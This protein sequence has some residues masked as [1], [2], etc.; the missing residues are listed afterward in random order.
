MQ[1]CRGVNEFHYR[2]KLMVM[3]ALESQCVGNKKQQRRTHAFA[4]SANDVFCDLPDQRHIR[5]KALADDAIDGIHV[6]R[7]RRV[8]LFELQG[9]HA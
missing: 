3:R 1:Q 5:M 7:D 4:A 9:W 8:E 6:G 2:S